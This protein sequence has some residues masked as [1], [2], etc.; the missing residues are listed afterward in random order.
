MKAV[1]TWFDYFLPDRYLLIIR[2]ESLTTIDCVHMYM[3]IWLR[4]IPIT[5]LGTEL[6]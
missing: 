6:L 5:A 4:E 3:Y 2:P 1:L